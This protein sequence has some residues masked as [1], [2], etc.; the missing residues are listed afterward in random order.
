MDTTQHLQVEV[1]FRPTASGGRQTS[2]HLTLGSYRP[3]LATE[4]SGLLGVAFVQSIL[5]V[6]QPGDTTVATVA[7]MYS[8]VD[9]ST[10]VPGAAF[11]VLEGSQVRRRAIN[12]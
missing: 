6:V 2:V 1:W 4:S 9:Y 3:H 10:L 8:G 5:A 7:L 11:R 12:R